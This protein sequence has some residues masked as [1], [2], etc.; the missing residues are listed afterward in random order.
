M[1]TLLVKNGL[2]YDGTEASAAK[3]DILIRGDK[4]VAVGALSR[5]PADKVVDAVGG[6]VIPGIVDINTDSDHFLSIFHEPYQLDFIRQGITTII[7]GNC[8]ASLAPLIDGSLASVRQWGD[9]SKVNVNWRSMGEFL[10]L[11]GERKIGLNFG[12]L[13]GH[14]TI[15]QAITQDHIRDLTQTEIDAFKALLAQSL[16]EGALGLS[17][18]LSYLH[19]RRASYREMQELVGVV[20]QRKAVYAVH[21]RETEEEMPFALT[22]TIEMARET[23]VNL[24]ISHFQPRKRFSAAYRQ[25]KELIE[26]EGASHR[27]NFDCY[28]FESLILPIA[29]LLPR[30]VQEEGMGKMLEYINADH[31]QSRL[32]EHFRKLR[33]DDISIGYVPTP[34]KHLVGKPLAEFAANAN[35]QPAEALLRLMRLTRLKAMVFYRA[36][37]ASLLEEFLRSPQAIISSNGASLPEEDFKH[38][39]NYNTFPK[40]L[41]WA[42]KE[43]GLPLEK[44]VAKIT[45]LPAQK[46]GLVNRGLIKEGY[47]ADVVILHDY[48]PTETIVNGQLALA[49]G[50][51]TKILAGRIL[52]K[53]P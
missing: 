51:P 35:L 14:G 19:S 1:N 53:S 20:S 33:A 28:P 48:W 31:L 16:E 44:A 8:G 25:A 41:E 37:D 9:I 17:S 23:G 21:L 7:G 2:V 27:V 5:R 26:K 13:V 29:A 36:I 34:L 45:S 47:A 30:W 12:T 43:N 39:R 49:A 42:A 50:Q 22:E 38:E 4:I 32:L 6:R 40:F 3:K 18:G 24:E 46:Y 15:R 52:K 11:L 10:N